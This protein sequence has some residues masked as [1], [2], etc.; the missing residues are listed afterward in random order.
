MRLVLQRV[1]KASVSKVESGEIVGQINQGLFV[2]IGVK[3]EDTKEIADNLAQKLFKLRVM[4]DENQKMNRSV[5]DVNG[6]FLVVS[7]FTLYANTKEGNRPSFIEAEDQVSAKVIY[8]HFI[9]KLKDLGAAVEVGSFGEY[10]SIE[11]S[12]DGPVTII[13]ES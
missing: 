9:S 8:E 10:M 7:Q 2:L 1:S 3:K 13:I 11:A 5:N 4:S 12:L 6:K